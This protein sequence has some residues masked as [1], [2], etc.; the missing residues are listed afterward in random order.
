MHDRSR[1]SRPAAAARA[2]FSDRIARRLDADS[3]EDV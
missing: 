3:L 1:Y 2:G